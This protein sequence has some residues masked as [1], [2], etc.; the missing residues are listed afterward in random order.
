VAA[1]VGA[2]ATTRSWNERPELLIDAGVDV[3]VVD[4]AHGHSAIGVL[5]P[6]SAASRCQ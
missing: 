3:L 1:A 4:T 6:W 5:E 2:W